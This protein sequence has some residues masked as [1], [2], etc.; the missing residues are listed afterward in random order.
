MFLL[1]GLCI[2]PVIPS[3]LQLSLH[4]VALIRNIII[5]KS[6]LVNKN[7]HLLS[8]FTM[9]R[10]TNCNEDDSMEKEN[11][12]VNDDKNNLANDDENSCH[13]SNVYVILISQF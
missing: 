2:T 11:G 5:V 10:S 9:V 13:Y 3:L 6:T 12:P 7:F 4:L 8:E 1:T